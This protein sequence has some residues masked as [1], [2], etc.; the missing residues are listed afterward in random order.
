MFTIAKNAKDR[1]EFAGCT[2]SPDGSILFVNM[3]G[4]GKTLAITGPWR[5]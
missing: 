2:F 5:T 3:Q 4:L 1:S